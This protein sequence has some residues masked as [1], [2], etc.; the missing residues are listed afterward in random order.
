MTDDAKSPELETIAV[1]AGG[2]HDPETGA[3]TPPIHLATTYEH[4]ADGTGGHG[5]IYVRHGNPTEQRLERALAAIER[6]DSALVFSSGVAA[7]TAVLQTL[8]AGSHVIFPLDVYANFR[9]MGETQFARWNLEASFVDMREIELVRAAIRPSTRLIWCETPSN[10]L[11]QIVDLRAVAA[12]SR[13]AETLM[14]VDNTFATPVLQR[15]LEL[16]ADIILHSTT[17]Y[18]GGHSDVQGGALVFSSQRSDL[19]ARLREYRE[20]TG[21]VASPFNSWLVL[22]GL[23]SL[24]PR[25]ERHCRNAVALATAIDGH[26][27]L[28]AVHYPGLAT[29]PGHEIA[30][31]QMS[32]FGGMV[33][34]QVRGGRAAAVAVASR[35]RL[36][37]NATSLGGAESLI[38]LRI[39]MEGPLSRSPENLLRLSVGLEHERD[40]IADIMQA[41]E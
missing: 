23:R 12:V 33:S 21:A 11:L 39:A 35:A 31:R 4:G 40:L 24:A 25:M 17:K 41:L 10:P 38:E 36:F 20:L 15:P 8:P 27:R 19:S 13:E 29:D 1:H 3:I 16:G 14:V 7:G 6:G 5:F 30:R 22:R 28:E 9:T 18:F 26:E 2:E 32:M 34:I 37:A